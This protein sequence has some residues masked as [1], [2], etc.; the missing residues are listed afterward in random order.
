M[1]YVFLELETDNSRMY[2]KPA[3]GSWI[4]VFRGKFVF[5]FLYEI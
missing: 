1:E 2:H 3:A 5:G 4:T